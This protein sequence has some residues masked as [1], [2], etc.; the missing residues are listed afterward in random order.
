MLQAQQPQTSGPAPQKLVDTSKGTLKVNV[1]EGEGAKNNIRARSAAAPVVEVKDAADKPVPG[2]E[3]V[4]Q[5]PMV[6]PSGTFNGWLKTQTV[7]TDE[8]GKATVNGYAPNSEAGRFNIKVTA[9]MGSQTGSAV[10][11]QSNIEGGNGTTGVAAKSTAWR[12]WVAL[13]GAAGAIGGIAA[14]ARGGNNGA[15]TT[16]TTPITISAGSVAVSTPR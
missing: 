5:L 9:T 11:A 6:G 8:Q 16:P 1:L 4:F 15:A 12:K 10:I 3:V 13:F 14:A 2:A 7:R